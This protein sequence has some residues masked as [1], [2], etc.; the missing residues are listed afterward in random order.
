VAGTGDD[1]KRQT[2]HTFPVALGHRVL[3]F[4]DYTLEL[5]PR[6][7]EKKHIPSDL[8]VDSCPHMLRAA[9]PLIS[10]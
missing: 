7:R 5:T 1:G 10:R 3:W 9:Q 8:V 2:Q 4:E 6:S